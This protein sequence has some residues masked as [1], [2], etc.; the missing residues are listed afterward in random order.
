[1]ESAMRSIDHIATDR[2]AVE[3]C[4]STSLGIEFN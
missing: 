1:M 3:C 4:H 2:S